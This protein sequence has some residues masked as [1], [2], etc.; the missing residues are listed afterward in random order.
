M[1]LVYLG[2]E[3]PS[4]RKILAESGIKYVGLSFMG[5][6]R[7]V[8]HTGNWF[9]CEKYQPGTHVYLDSGTYSLQRGE[10]LTDVRLREL[11]AEYYDFA[12]DNIKDLEVVAEF[13]AQILGHAWLEEQRERYGELF[14]DKWM[15]IWHSD[16]DDLLNR[17]CG[18]YGRVGILQADVSEDRTADLNYLA[19][20]LGT[21]L[22]GVGMSRMDP[23]RA[24][25][26]DSV[27]STSWTSSI[28]YG[29]T[30]VWTGRELKRYPKRYKEQ[31]RKRH[32]TLFEQN[33]FDAAKIE[34]DDSIEVLR[35]SLWSWEHFVA[36]IN[37]KVTQSPE[38]PETQNAE[39]AGGE[40]DHNEQDDGQKSMLPDQLP[41]RELTPMPVLGFSSKTITVPGEGGGTEEHQL[42][43]IE[44]RSDS[45]RMCNTCFLKDKCP[46]YQPG[47]SCAYNLPVEIRTRE[48]RVALW[49]TLI[50]WQTQRVAFMMM[51]EQLEGGYAD[52]NVSSEMDRLGKL[53]KAKEDA[54]KQGFSLK[55]EASQ[56]GP[57]NGIISQ[58]LGAEAGAKLHELES[59]QAV[60]EII[61]QSEIIDAEVVD[62]E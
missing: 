29:D 26:W 10:E 58:L 56:S 55:I 6:K 34:A 46:A 61:R 14:G 32:R 52:P 18:I 12:S 31:A 33:G 3:V 45:M 17:L 25:Q 57:Q 48:Q 44:S 42:P 43:I 47:N 11:A 20:N 2:S 53:L 51:S 19:R 50:E 40:V 1:K 62:N 37:R 49:D 41:K 8:K 21:K 13:D 60:D 38:V 59:P 24:V 9:A 15:P 23:M 36:D 39:Q 5:L 27:A 35:L 4:H 28:A 16:S 22:H 54:E 30:F 7:R